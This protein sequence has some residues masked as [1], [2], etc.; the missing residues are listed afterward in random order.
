MWVVESPR[1][2]ART[3]TKIESTETAQVTEPEAD[4][5]EVQAFQVVDPEASD[6][7]AR[8][9]AV[10]TKQVL[11]LVADFLTF[12]ML[13]SALVLMLLVCSVQANFYSIVVNYYPRGNVSTGSSTGILYYKL[14]YSSCLYSLPYY[15]GGQTLVLDKVDEESRGEWCQTE[16]VISRLFSSNSI[17][18][19]P[20]SGLNWI[21]GIKNGIVSFKIQALVELRIRSDIGK[22]NTSPQT[23]II[24]AIRVPSNC[25]RDFSLLM[26]DPDGDQV[27]CRYGNSSLFECNG[28]DP[29]SVLSLSSSTCTLS[30]APTS[31]SNVGSYGVQL[32]MEDF[33]MKNIT[34]TGVN[35]T[36][37]TQTPN[38]A[39]SKVPIQFVLIVDP[40]VSSCTEGDFLPKFL[41]PTPNNRARLY[42][43]V[44]K[45]LE[46]SISA[47]AQNSTISEL[48]FSGPYDAIQNK[49]GP[50]KFT[51][52]WTPSKSQDND[53]LPFCFVVQALSKSVPFYKF[54]P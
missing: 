4:N 14:G 6:R 9:A 35:G 22:A 21:F 1:R 30:F 52:T 11:R 44:D 10:V 12:I 40:P 43:P 46:I 24:P 19:I 29:P 49:T 53:T 50:G 3:I 31:D 34:M 45:T 15:I 42:T 23:T 32:L 26:F 47:E 39:L 25:R 18:S 51:L 54:I 7:D 38:D 17:F 2:R 5:T 28:C 20:V 48:L 33:P 13:R 36:K 37:T 27:K 41:P 16:G 8:K